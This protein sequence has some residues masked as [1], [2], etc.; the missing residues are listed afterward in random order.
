V[1]TNKKLG[2]TT[3]LCNYHV[4]FCPKYLQ[5]ALYGR[6][7][8]RVRDWIRKVCGWK[9]I[10]ILDGSVSRDHV[11]LVLSIPPKYSVSEVIGTLQGWVAIRIFKEVREIGKKHWGRR[12][13]SRGYF[14][15][16]VGVT[17]AV[18]REYVRQQ[19]LRARKQN[20]SD[21]TGKHP[22]GVRYSHWV[23]VQSH[24]LC[25]RIIYLS[26]GEH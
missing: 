6:L 25:R 13:W 8:E 18:I 17:E 26:T 10:E 23:P 12:F 7:G 1:D 11:H 4:V 14:V 19:E 24:R 22:M 21:W 20:S 2:H 15:S 9:G 16:T 5:R 3:Y